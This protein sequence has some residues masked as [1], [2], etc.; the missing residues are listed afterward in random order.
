[1]SPRKKN[2]NEVTEAIYKMLLERFGEPIGDAPAKPGVP[3]QREGDGEKCGK[4]FFPPKKSGAAYRV[5]CKRPDGHEGPCS[6]L[7][8]ADTCGMD[9]ADD[10]LDQVTPPGGEKVV[11]ALKKKKGVKNPW[12]VAWAM[13][14]RGQI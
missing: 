8:E 11:R 12:A 9:E 3:D 7:D 4:S 1:M 5:I 2:V 10:D 13:K 6:E 14:N